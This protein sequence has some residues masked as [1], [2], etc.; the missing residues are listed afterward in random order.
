[1][2]EQ[3]LQVYSACQLGLNTI[4]RDFLIVVES[5]ITA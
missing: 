3:G 2:A 1:M 4:L 5:A